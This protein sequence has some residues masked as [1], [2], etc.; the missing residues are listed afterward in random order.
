MRRRLLVVLWLV[1]LALAPAGAQDLVEAPEASAVV[2][3][4]RSLFEVVGLEGSKFT[5]EQ[6]AA[7]ISAR[8]V[9]AAKSWAPG[10]EVRSVVEGDSVGLYAGSQLILL[11]HAEDAAYH[12]VT[13]ERSGELLAPILERAILDYRHERS[14][15]RML[16]SFALAAA[17]L[18]GTVVILVLYSRVYRRLR[19]W[20]LL[21]TGRRLAQVEALSTAVELGRV[22]SVL[23]LALST[24]NA[25][26]WVA[27]AAVFVELC[28]SLFPQTRALSAGLLALV[29]EPLA[30]TGRAALAS[31]PSLIFV[32]VVVVVTRLLVQLCGELFDRLERGTLVVQ[33]FYPEW[34]RPT[35]RVVTIALVVAG[36]VVAFPY[37]PG[38][39][40]AAFKSI[41]ILL[42][43]V[44]SLGS[45]S[46]VSNFLNGLMLTY[47]RAFRVGDVVRIDDTLGTVLESGT[48][49][50]RLRTL[51]ETEMVI[52]NM[53]IMSAKVVNFSTSGVPLVSTVVTIGYGTPWRQVQAMLELAAAETAG[54][55]R[56]PAPFVLQSGLEDFYIRYELWVALEDPW[57]LPR[58]MAALHA[59]I[60]DQFNE[61]G[62]QI[63]SPHYR[64]DPPEPAVVP[65][66][67]WR[68]PPAK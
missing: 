48:M 63:M 12:G 60:Q 36:V 23:G 54:I 47:M 17:L 26:V 24:V 27:L 20:I 8:L 65:K 13:L 57:Q 28:L 43:V 64:S 41:S 21:G 40:S 3:D 14:A 52:P 30:E 16:R 51:R 49:V 22:R 58:V 1:G 18:L 19:A 39:D 10:S 53:T 34:A 4:G 68:L 55:R 5:A 59:A 2:L 29:A 67:K 56:D 31:I 35:S 62:V 45:S 25:L 61:H 9:E 50:T 15:A 32:A 38:S 66:E 11:L 33:G 6:R 46:V 44:V 7:V 37:I 42:G